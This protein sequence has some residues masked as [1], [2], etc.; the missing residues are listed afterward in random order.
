MRWCEL[1]AG[2]WA[3][4]HK[5]MDLNLGLVTGRERCLVVDT[6]F[7]A[8]HGG[9]VARGVRERTSL[10]WE[11]VLTHAHVDH[12]FGTA[13]FGGA[14]VYG[15][16]VCANA[17][18]VFGE[19]ER[20]EWVELLHHDELPEM[21]EPFLATTPVLPT[22]EISDVT[23]DLGDRLVR[24]WHPG[25][26][27]TGGDLVVHVPDAAVVF[28][29]DLVEEGVFPQ[30][31]VDGFPAEWPATL[32]QVLTLHPGIVVPG[33]GEPVDAA[34]VAAL[35]EELRVRASSSEMR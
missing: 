23:L 24:L 12:A 34:F 26:G 4:R 21:V 28:T 27:H 32:D 22:H 3:I 15:H 1:A 17:L 14:D 18:R 35:R 30:A 13:A 5:E 16:P 19:S 8:R 25:R 11:V 29:G 2:V 20:D 31:D 6:G 33:H 7:D 9:E 10:P